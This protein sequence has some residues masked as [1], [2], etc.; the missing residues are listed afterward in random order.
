MLLIL[1]FGYSLSWMN[2]AIGISAKDPENAQN[3]GSG[4]AFLLMFASN[5]IVPSAKLP[6]WLQ[7]FARDQPLSVTTSA[8]RE[9]F[10]GS[11]VGTGAWVSMGWSA[12]ITVVFFLMS[13]TLYERAAAT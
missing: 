4:P 11:P 1:A 2:T 5:A 13:Y 9:L 6:G 12:G 7:G 10:A 3:A 8:I